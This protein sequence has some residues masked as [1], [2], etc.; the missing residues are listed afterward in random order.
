MGSLPTVRIETG[1]GG[2][3]FFFC[4]AAGIGGVQTAQNLRSTLAE[5]ITRENWQE[6]LYQ[7]Q[8][9]FMVQKAKTNDYDWKR[10]YN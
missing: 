3:C 9:G 6:S 2:D 10:P 1:G 8:D 7:I 4:V 5:Q